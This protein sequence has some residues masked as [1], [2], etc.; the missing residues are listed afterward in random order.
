MNSPITV[1]TT[2]ALSTAASTRPSSTPTTPI[3]RTQP[4]K[5]STTTTLPTTPP[6][7]IVRQYNSAPSWV[8]GWLTHWLISG[9]R[10]TLIDRTSAATSKQ[11]QE[12]ILIGHVWMRG[13][14]LIIR[15]RTQITRHSKV[16]TRV[17]ELCALVLTVLTVWCNVFFRIFYVHRIVI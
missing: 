3:R 7:V 15:D 14:G 9:R 6:A 5:T 8:L 13:H 17:W 10:V 12:T 2:P 16:R 4:Q 11:A 1:K